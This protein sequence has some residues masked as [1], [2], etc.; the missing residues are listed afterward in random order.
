MVDLG[1]FPGYSTTARGIND[2]GEIVG[3]KYH[4]INEDSF[5]SHGLLWRR[6]VS[7]QY[8]WT[9]LGEL[10]EFPNS[11]PRSINN[12][13]RIA[14]WAEILDFKVNTPPAQAVMWEKDPS[15]GGYAPTDLGTPYSFLYS[16]AVGFDVLNEA[17]QIVGDG[18]A[19][20]GEQ[21]AYLWADPGLAP[22]VELS[23]AAGIFGAL[24]INNAGFVVG[25]SAPRGRPI[26]WRKDVGGYTQVEL[27]MPAGATEGRAYDINDDGQIV[28]AVNTPAPATVAV[29]W[30]KSALGVYEPHALA[31]P[32]GGLNGWAHAINCSGEVVGRVVFNESGKMVGHAVLWREDPPGQLTPAL[33][34]ELP[35][36][37]ASAAYGVNDKGEIVGSASIRDTATGT[38]LGHAVL[39]E[40]PD[41]TPPTIGD[42]AAF[43]AVLW[44]PNH[45]L[46]DVTIGYQATDDSGSVACRLGPVTCNETATTADWRVV[47]DHRIQLRSERNGKGRGRVY[48]I[49]IEC[50]DPSGNVASQVVAVAVPHDQRR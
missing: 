27:P 31:L 43:P 12:S 21:H 11:Y 23:P 5:E 15:G 2:A 47:D 20:T 37:T 39:W 7:G 6:G 26:L 45:E 9:E 49:P 35:G 16:Q 24:G 46:V 41:E 1:A 50:R 34:D 33:L 19:Y 8:S 18:R 40:R 38:V 32:P 4:F 17:G 28:G 3:E 25:A 36:T 29:I 13:G 10:A 22:P 44:P 48:T 14:G 30:E 42:A